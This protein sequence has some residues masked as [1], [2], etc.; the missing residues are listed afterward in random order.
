MVVAGYRTYGKVPMLL[1]AFKH[2]PSGLK[3]KG[4]GL[5]GFYLSKFRRQF[6]NQCRDPDSMAD[7]RDLDSPGVIVTWAQLPS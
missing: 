3:S 5:A 4:M 1:P 2:Y 7:I 6:L